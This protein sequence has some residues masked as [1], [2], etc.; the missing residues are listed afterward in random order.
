MLSSTRVKC[1]GV[2]VTYIMIT[3]TVKRC[4]YIFYSYVKIYHPLLVCLCLIPVW[5]VAHFHSL[6]RPVPSLSHPKHYTIAL[7]GI[8][9]HHR[10]HFSSSCFVCTALLYTLQPDLA[11]HSKA[12]PTASTRLILDDNFGYG[13]DGSLK[14]G[15]I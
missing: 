12:R 11:S 14:H 4:Y 8:W 5:P 6:I 7:L 9:P 13:C 10:I 3:Y 1:Y 15:T 2:V